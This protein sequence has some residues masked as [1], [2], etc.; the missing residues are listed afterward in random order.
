MTGPEPGT[1]DEALAGLARIARAAGIFEATWSGRTVTEVSEIIA[2]WCA[3]RRPGPSPAPPG[4]VVELR[5]W[6]NIDA[7]Q[8]VAEHPMAAG[9]VLPARPGERVTGAALT[10]AVANEPVYVRLSGRPA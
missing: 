5:A 4:S 9:L 8:D 1:L 2:A 3:A 7:G 6:G 10:P